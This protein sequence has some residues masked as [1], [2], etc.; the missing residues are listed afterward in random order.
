MD[1]TCR[2]SI[3]RSSG[4]GLILANTKG[5]VTEYT[6]RFNFKASNNQAKYEALLVDLK[7]AKEL[8]VNKLKVFTDSQLIVGHIKGEFEARDPTMAKYLQRAKDLIST[9]KYFEIFYIPR[10]E[11]ARTNALSRLTT[12]SFDIVGRTFNEYLEQPSI[13]KVEEVLQIN[14]E[15]SWMDPVRSKSLPVEVRRDTKSWDDLVRWR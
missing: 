13:D 3:Q 10:T 4:A 11:N 1:T 5:T 8:E 9:F 12:T 15:S 14:D 7:I 2:W 6:L